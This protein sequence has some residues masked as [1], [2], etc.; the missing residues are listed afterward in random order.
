MVISRVC[1]TIAIILM[2]IF[3]AASGSFATIFVCMSLALSIGILCS[4]YS[5]RYKDYLYCPK[6]GSKNIVKTGFLGI[7]MSITDTCPDCK[8]KINIDKGINQD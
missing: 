3:F 2:I 7:P 8:Q 1:Y 4:I 6:C 5:I